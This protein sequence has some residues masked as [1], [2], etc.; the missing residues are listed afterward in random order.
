M[1]SKNSL[2]TKVIAEKV[3]KKQPIT[4]E[5][6]QALL[7]NVDWKAHDQRV[8][9]ALNEPR[10]SC[11]SCYDYWFKWGREAY[12]DNLKDYEER[13]NEALIHLRNK[14]VAI[15]EREKSGHPIIYRCA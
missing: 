2:D 14:Q 8:V 11:N 9:W 3:K 10:C 6:F 15:A 5:E 1:K 7:D 4:R 12:K 13:K